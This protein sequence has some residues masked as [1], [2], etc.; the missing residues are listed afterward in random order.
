M[1]IILAFVMLVATGLQA[2]SQCDKKV[3][4]HASKVDMIDT[5]GN[6]LQNKEGMILFE[7][8]PQKLSLSFKESTEE[9]L[10]GMVKAKSCEWKE[11]F[12]NGKS[13]YNTTVTIDG[14]SSNAIFTLEAKESKIVLTVEI[15]IMEG[16]KF[17]VYIDNY[18][19]IK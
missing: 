8:D 15:E 11:P 4:W 10:E 1:K 12:R 13:N 19:E 14:R 17:Q 18:E 7:T 9:G 6:L 5:K 3:V 16:R 2:K